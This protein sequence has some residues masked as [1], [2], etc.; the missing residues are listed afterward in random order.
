MNEDE[1][2]DLEKY[3]NGEYG[4]EKTADIERQQ[5]ERPL[6]VKLQSIIDDIDTEDMN[7][8]RRDYYISKIKN[9]FV[10]H[11]ENH[12]NSRNA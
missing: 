5:Y 2:I 9:T 3:K 7:Q 8:T 4:E 11:S 6:S 12:L 1:E 10:E